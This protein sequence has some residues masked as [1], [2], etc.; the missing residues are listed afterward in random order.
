MVLCQRC[1]KRQA[2]LQTAQFDPTSGRNIYI[3]LCKQ[4]FDE[5]QNDVSTSSNELLKFG[6]DLTE[7]AKN[8]KLDP[9]VGRREEIE[10]VIHVLARRIKNNPVLI[11]EPG[12]GKTAIVEG[13]A[14]RIVN[15]QVPEVLRGKR[16]MTIDMASLVAGAAHRGVFEKRLKD[17]IKEVQDAKGQI[18]LFIDELHT[19]V[20]A[21]AAEGSIDAANILKPSL[22]RGE[23]QLIGATTLDEYRKR[24]EKDAALERRF[25]TVLVREPSQKETVLILEG[26]IPRYEEHHKVKYTKSAIKAAVEFSSKY[27]SDK[28]LP[29]KAIDLIDEAGARVRI[30]TV[31]EPE[32]LKEVNTQIEKLQIKIKKAQNT[33]LIELQKQLDDLQQIKN[34]I[35]ELWTKTKLEKSPEVTKYDIATVISQATGIP[36]KQLSQEERERLLNLEKEMQKQ[37]VGQDE[38]VTAVAKS[39]RRS[40]SGLKDPN[41]PIG[42]F[43]FLGPTGV[44]KTELAKALTKV[45]Y[46]DESLLVRLDMTE[47]GEKH[48]SSRLVGA[49][50]GYVGFDDAGQLT[51]VVRRRPFSV[52]LLDEIEKA[53]QDVYNILLQIMDDGRLT[54]GHGRTVNFKNTIIIMTSNIG[55]SVINKEKIGFEKNNTAHVKAHEK[56]LDN[57]DEILKEQFKPEF[58]N[59]VDEIV[60]FKELEKSSIKEIVKIQ[61]E[62]VSELLVA[63]KIKLS[64]TKEVI[65]YI[66]SESFSYEYGARPVKRY[67][68]KNVS[69]QISTLILSEGVE[70]DATVKIGLNKAKKSLVFDLV[71]K[72]KVKV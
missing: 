11:G 31:K 2:E 57:L 18:I 71:Q 25:Q 28:F 5:I 44:G 10:R 68:Q 36:L 64:Y 33:A 51:E 60:V 47:Y 52:I 59:R 62:R 14:Q 4:C 13:L 61:L 9:V 37:V 30:A 42:V 7:M 29:D 1:Q 53:H 43:M 55:T 72:V 17:I 21:G 19:V 40:R 69:D 38:A 45:L 58:I 50:P 8:N 22:A 67:V 23:L 12:V 26:L 15:N 56:L 41:R 27:I 48:T 39:I 54:D 16:V 24:I 3:A 6:S 20:G 63:S 66:A 35:M 65:D 49:P 34:E 32:N 70:K 46:G